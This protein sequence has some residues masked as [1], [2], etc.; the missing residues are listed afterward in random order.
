MFI[1][2]S[3]KISD[4]YYLKP[5]YFICF[6]E[7][8]KKIIHKMSDQTFEDS[9]IELVEQYPVLYDLGNMNY[10]RNDVKNEAW[11]EIHH[12][13]NIAEISGK[14]FHTV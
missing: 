3:Q 14:F 6:L 4:F 2:K 5:A 13:L 10:K 8:K 1:N 12:K 7:A 11:N 9:L